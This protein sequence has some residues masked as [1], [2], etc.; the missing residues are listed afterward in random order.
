MDKGIGTEMEGRAF[1]I[2]RTK[3]SSLPILKLCIPVWDGMTISIPVG[4][5]SHFPA[6]L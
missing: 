2:L 5:K 6:V 4:E 3:C 1:K